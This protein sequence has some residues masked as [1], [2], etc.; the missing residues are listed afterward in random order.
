MSDPIH[1][2]LR[3]GDRPRVLERL[4]ELGF[5]EGGIHTLAHTVLDTFDGRFAEAGLRLVLQEGETR[6]L[7]LTGPGV[8]P[9]AVRVD[10]VPRFA[11]DLPRG[12]F[13]A[14]LVDLT[15]VRALLPKMKVVARVTPLVLRDGAGKAVVRVL[16]QDQVDVVGSDGAGVPEGIV[17]VREVAGFP[18]AGKRALAALESLALPP[19]DGDAFA[20][21]ATGAGMDLGGHQDSPTVPL[22]PG[23]RAVDGFAAVL[24]NLKATVEANWQG[25]L[26][27][28]DPEF[29]H[30]LRVAL[31][32][33]RAVLGQGKKV[34]PPD[35]VPVARERFAE[36][37]R[38]TG[39]AR[40][41][42]VYVIE[43][44]GYVQPL[45]A[46]VA[47][48]LEPVRQFLEERLRTAHGELEE[49][50]RSPET[51]ELME[52]WDRWLDEL[53]PHRPQGEHA[54]RKLGRVVRQQVRKAQEK[55]VHDGRTI[56]PETP[57]ERLH[58]LRKDA[59]KV[60]YLL[61][62]F[63][64]LLPPEATRQYV[65]RLKALQNNLGEH[66]DAEVHVA[67]IREVA[68][69]LNQR[70]VEPRT[71]IA[72]GQLTERLEQVRQASRAEFAERFDSYDSRATEDALDAVLHG[73]GS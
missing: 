60:R 56:G 24:A 65:K 39:P 45:G 73:I 35:I 18:K 13:R 32:R 48:A 61:E 47:D 29:L 33:T 70:G 59:K 19:L 52:Q 69:E 11:R 42:D 38:L 55:L 40:D 8:V 30:D 14:R 7:S 2:E 37:A 72:I 34:L 44:D 67:L 64:S 41:L 58:D 12:P 43:W 31:R 9:A 63:G 68:D 53:G 57:A 62:C 1:L 3:D 26:D 46:E 71:L 50:M 5:E 25:T 16:V 23:M 54:K 15:E 66:Q 4:R 20:A 51:A 6:E 36:F 28:V 21:Y 49:A 17:E 27:Q 10:S 22:D